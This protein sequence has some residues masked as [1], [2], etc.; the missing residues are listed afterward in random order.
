MIEEK[1]NEY[2]NDDNN[3][4]N[5]NNNDDDNNNEDDNNDDN[6]EDNNEDDNEDRNIKTFSFGGWNLIN[7]YGE[8]FTELLFGDNTNM[9]EL[10]RQRLKPIDD[11]RLEFTMIVGFNCKDKYEKQITFDKLPRLQQLIDALAKFESECYF[12]VENID[13]EEEFFVADTDFH[14]L[15]YNKNNGTIYLDYDT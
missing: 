11:N 13:N 12:N 7:K 6:N 1:I 4:C 3:D 15:V 14:S 2:N 8:M 10:A 5:D 9:Y